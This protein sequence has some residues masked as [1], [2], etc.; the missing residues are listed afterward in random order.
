MVWRRRQPRRPWSD[1]PADESDAIDG[2]ESRSSSKSA[3]QEGERR[4]KLLLDLTGEFLETAALDDLCVGQAVAKA[5]ALRIPSQ[6]DGF[7]DERHHVQARHEE[8]GVARQ[9]ATGADWSAAVEAYHRQTEQEL[10][11][12][13]AAETVSETRVEGSQEE[14]LQ[15]AASRCLQGGD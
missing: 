2:R 15:V 7:P 5:E 10:A 12:A 3:V 1:L 13:T 4:E 9:G 14:D 11:E 8:D 6:E